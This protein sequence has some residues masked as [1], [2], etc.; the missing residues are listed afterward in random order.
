MLGF[1]LPNPRGVATPPLCDCQWG[2]NR[3]FCFKI[4]DLSMG[5]GPKKT[6]NAMTQEFAPLRPCA[7]K[8][9]AMCDALGHDNSAN[10]ILGHL[11]NS[12]PNCLNCQ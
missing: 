10:A 6:A 4:R 11:G 3:L 12:K 5:Q 7:T 1:L 2:K 9:R 8:L